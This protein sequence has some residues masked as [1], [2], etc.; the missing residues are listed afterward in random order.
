MHEVKV[1]PNDDPVSKVAVIDTVNQLHIT[2]KDEGAEVLPSVTKRK[3]IQ[4]YYRTETGGA[5]ISFETEEHFLNWEKK[6]DIKNHEINLSDKTPFKESHR[7]LSLALFQDRK[8][9]L[10]EMFEASV[11][12]RCTSL[13]SSNAVVR[14]I[15]LLCGLEATR[16]QNKKGR[17][18]HS[19]GGRH[20]S[21]TSQIQML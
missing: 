5:Y 17:S 18:Y 7:G 9:L 15:S 3:R 21:L 11:I 4:I 14:K 6:C 16:Q 12:G 8:E 10:K 2:K 19:Q 13:F 1:F 20:A